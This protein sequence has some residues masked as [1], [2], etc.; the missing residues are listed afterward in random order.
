MK[1]GR[2]IFGILLL[3]LW[4]PTVVLA[5]PSVLFL[6]SYTISFDTLPAQLQGIREAL[7][8]EDFDV[9]TEFMDT[10][11]FTT[12]ADEQEFHRLLAYKLRQLPRYDA[13]LLG[14]DAALL[15]AMRYQQELF[16]DTPMA[17]FCVNDPELA[18]TAAQNPQISGVRENMDYDRNIAL[19]QQIL[20]NTKRIVGISDSTLTGLGDQ[21]QF[22]ENAAHHPELEFSLLNPSKYTQE[23]LAQKLQEMEE[24]SVLLYLTMFEDGDKN[25]YTIQSA[26]QFLAAS[27]NVPIFRMSIGGMGTGVMGGLMISYEESGRKAGELVR[28]R[29]DGQ[30]AAD[31]PLVLDT[32]LHGVF[33]KDVLD[34]YHIPTWKLPVGSE[35]LNQKLTFYE[36]HRELCMVSSGVLFFLGI[37][38]LVLWKSAARRKR[39][40]N[41]DYLTGLH[42]RR[43]ITEELRQRLE[44][45][46]TC[47]VL[48]LDMDGFKHIND[49]YGHLAGDELLAQAA[50]RLQ[51]VLPRHLMARLGGDEFFCIGESNRRG[52]V[53]IDCER[54]LEAFRQPFSLGDKKV[55]MSVSIGIAFVPE[56]GCGVDTLMTYADAAM[57]EVKALGR[58]G[59]RFF[60]EKLQAGLQRDIRVRELLTEA[61][62]QDGFE[63]FYQPQ[64]QADT[65]RLIGFE[66]LLRLKNQQAM[67]SEFIPIAEQNRQILEIGRTVLKKA[68]QQLAAWQAKGY[69]LQRIAVNFSNQQLHDATYP[70]YVQ[71][72][73]EQYKIK[74]DSLEIEVTESIYLDKSL[75]T[76]DFM[77]QLLRLG[78]RLSLD[79]FGTGYSAIHY[80]NYIPFAQMKLDKTLL[81]SCLA[82]GDTR[83]I[84]GIIRLAHSLGMAVTAEGVEAPAQ[85]EMLRGFDCDYIQ[86]Y[87]LGR[88][89]AAADAEAL[90]Q[91]KKRTAFVQEKDADTACQ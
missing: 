40:M 67:P 63:L 51:K 27:S 64:F 17:F 86:G 36:L 53:M 46:Q 85:L 54:I 6:S 23:E 29:M 14:D 89:L 88:P 35:I 43:W 10:K 4:F 8:P 34:A 68:V 50:A 41:E 2:F 28:A 56:G 81:D 12:Q 79:D 62:E 44:K 7:P 42:N 21:R 39:I 71:A 65:C 11:R 61:M 22:W 70:A 87:L 38:I 9:D 57:Y 13:V 91:Q 32:P 16:P 24:G 49:A 48:M 72:L 74:P 73:L 18:R 19:I 77:E 82:K 52:D 84:G 80:L 26:A 58:H 90:L 76:L 78:V 60:D 1:Q 30:N 20:P 59:Y 45:K 47:S 31:M 25:T 75:L 37:I 55:R 15:F 33:D 83:M 66:A 69:N 5:K 3:C